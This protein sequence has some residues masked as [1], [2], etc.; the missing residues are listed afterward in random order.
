MDLEYDVFERFPDGSV[1]W[2]GFVVGLDAARA[3]IQVLAKQS[4]NELFAIHTPTKKI[5]ARVNEK[6]GNN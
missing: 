3:R 6:N 4:K 5:A 2:R 1:E